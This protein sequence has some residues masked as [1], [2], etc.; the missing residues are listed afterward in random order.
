MMFKDEM[1]MTLWAPIAEDLPHGLKVKIGRGVAGIVAADARPYTCN[2]PMSD[3]NWEGK[4]YGD[5]CTRNLLTV[6]VLHDWRKT[7]VENN[8]TNPN[9]VFAVLQALNKC[10]FETPSCLCVDDIIRGCGGRAFLNQW[11]PRDVQCMRQISKKVSKELLE[12]LSQLLGAKVLL[13]QTNDE[14]DNGGATSLLALVNAHYSVKHHRVTANSPVRST[15]K[16]NGDDE[17]NKMTMTIYNTASLSTTYNVLSWEVPYWKLK[18]NEQLAF[19]CKGIELLS[20]VPEHTE[21]S[22]FVSFFDKLRSMYGA[23]ILYHNFDHALQTF[24]C[25]LLYMIEALRPCTSNFPLRSP[26]YD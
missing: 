4:R 5:F 9:K 14:E 3:P 13:D 23:H 17:A 10:S 22:K 11:N 12:R 18:P 8:D 15:K 25:A 24:H 20:C 21:I 19:A 2:N 26:V 16:Q 1:S 6:P 7:M